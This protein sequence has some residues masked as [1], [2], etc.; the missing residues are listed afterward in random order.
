MTA[1]NKVLVIENTDSNWHES[2]ILSEAGYSVDLTQNPDLALQELDGQTYDVIILYEDREA[3]SCLICE[4]IRHLCGLPLI[5]ISTNASIETSVMAIKAGADYFI[6]KP[7]G[8]LEF[9]ARIQA[10][11]RRKS[12]CKDTPRCF[13]A[14]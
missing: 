6:R 14:S 8:P 5:V 1:D 2:S 7:F 10:L 11:L 3:D 4:R 9:L 12:P 13:S